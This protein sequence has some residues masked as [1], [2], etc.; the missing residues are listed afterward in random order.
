[1]YVCIPLVY[2]THTLTH[3]LD[4]RLIIVYYLIKATQHTLLI[5]FTSVIYRSLDARESVWFEDVTTAGNQIQS[6][7]PDQEKE[8]SVLCHQCTILGAESVV[9]AE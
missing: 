1:M 2:T 3:V 8:L 9:A 6:R 7:V 5:I 4:E